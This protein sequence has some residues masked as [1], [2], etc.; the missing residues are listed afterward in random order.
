LA[1]HPP[2][3]GR[4]VLL[5][6]GGA[7]IVGIAVLVIVI[8]RVASPANQHD[9]DGRCALHGLATVVMHNTPVAVATGQHTDILAIRNT[10]GADW[11]DLDVTISGFETANGR[12][13]PTGAYQLRTG[14]GAERYA[15]WSL[16]LNDFEKPS[17]EKWLPL[18]MTVD[19]IKVR[20]TLR[21]ESCSVDLTPNASILDVIGR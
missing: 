14:A 7:A 3:E 1:K 11:E 8:S 15:V 9:S 20:A 21:S 4:V 5:L 13:Q 6:F 2:S 12:R 10:D 17:G 16:E 18:T 19:D